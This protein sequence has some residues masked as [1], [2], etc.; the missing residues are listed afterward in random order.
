MWLGI[1]YKTRVDLP[2]QQGT[3][4]LLS[5]MAR[6]RRLDGCPDFRSHVVPQLGRLETADVAGKPETTRTP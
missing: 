3:C 6:R 5:Q 2:D 4:V 1:S